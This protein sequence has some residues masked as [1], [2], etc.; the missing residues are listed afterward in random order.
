MRIPRLHLSFLLIF[1]IL[2][3][4]AFA[5]FPTSQPFPGIIYAT[6]SRKDPTLRLYCVVI[7]LTNPAISLHVSRAG[8][9]PDGNGPFQT[10]LMRTTDIAARESF[11][12]TIHEGRNRQVRRMCDAVGHP[13]LRLVRTRI[14][15]I[16]DR[17]LK[18]GTW[19]ELT[20]PE[21]HALEKAVAGAAPR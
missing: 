6:E 4:L 3:V 2:P 5:E 1:F 7:D 17:T 16:T 15:P 9:D 21:V 13:V 8:P 12:I 18:P 19:R 14:G 20:K 10:T 11:D